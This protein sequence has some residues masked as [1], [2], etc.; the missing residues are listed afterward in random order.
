M[1]FALSVYDVFATA[2]PGSL[3]LST[4]VY[5][6]VRFDWFRPAPD[7]TANTFVISVLAFLLAY[8]IGHVS[9]GFGRWLNRALPGGAGWQDVDRSRQRFLA[10]CPAALG[11]PFVDADVFLLLT[12]VQLADQELALEI[13]RLRSNGLMLRHSV[14]P[15]AALTVVGLLELVVGRQGWVALTAMLLFGG[16]TWGALYHGRELSDWARTKTLEAAFWIPGIDAELA[17]PRP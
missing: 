4:L 11:R 2:I 15:L 13:S 16:A 14:P 17:P 6:G 12:R 7:L 10:K 9:Y 5:I 1:S 3:Y 8:L